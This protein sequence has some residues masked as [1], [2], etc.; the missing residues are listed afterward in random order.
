MAQYK[1]LLKS[2][3]TSSLLFIQFNEREENLGAEFLQKRA[4]NVVDEQTM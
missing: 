1:Y 4:E 3:Q 2:F